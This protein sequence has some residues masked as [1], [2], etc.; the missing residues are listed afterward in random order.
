MRIKI[1]ILFFFFLCTD[2]FFSS[3]KRCGKTTIIETSVQIIHFLGV[4]TVANIISDSFIK[5][6]DYRVSIELDIEFKK[7]SK[8]DE[9]SSVCFISSAYACEAQHLYKT[10][11]TIKNIEIVPNV[12][13]WNFEAGDTIKDIRDITAFFNRSG[14]NM[15]NDITFNRYGFDTFLG[16]LRRNYYKNYYMEF[17]IPL[18]TD[19]F[20]DFEYLISFTDDTKES[21]K[22]GRIKLIE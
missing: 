5:R 2:F 21:F 4:D 7:L 1:L 16:G 8:S 6:K 9:K 20:V 12:P 13:V 11:R 22:P 3:C 19:E 17:T 18:D 10:A 15:Q 14:N